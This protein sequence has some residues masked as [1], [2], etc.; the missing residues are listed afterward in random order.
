MKI[1]WVNPYNK[2]HVIGNHAGYVLANKRLMDAVG[3][4]VELDD[5]AE[6]ALHFYHPLW[7]KAIEGKVN[8]LYTMCESE[9]EEYFFPDLAGKCD[10]ILTP[11]EFCRDIL[12]RAT[13]IPIRVV[14]LG[15]DKRVF[16]YK[17]RKWRPERGEKFRWLFLGAPNMRKYSIMDEI[18]EMYLSKM[19][20]DMEL[21]VKTTGADIEGGIRE[22]RKKSSYRT[23]DLDGELFRHNNCIIDNRF[24]ETEEL[25]KL[26]HSSHGMLALHM[27][28][29]WGQNVI[30]CMATGLPVV[31]SDYSGTRDFANENNAYPVGVELRETEIDRGLIS[32]EETV[33]MRSAVPDIRQT[34]DA[35]FCVISDYKTAT[36][37]AKAA[38]LVGNKFSWENSARKLAR[39]VSELD[40]PS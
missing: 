13:S 4:V 10:L 8:V 25:V 38:S 33:K 35:M 30:E 14:P 11:S 19:P 23:I 6:V 21:Y 7:F 9:D 39:V 20:D 15:V 1:H 16:K 22:L 28:E 37:K 27:G 18:F 40:S 17:K 31:V 3:E 5:K 29:G 12:S 26:I 34:L 24:L 2:E 32:V 36:K